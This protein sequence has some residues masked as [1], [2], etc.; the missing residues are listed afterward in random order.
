[1]T[2]GGEVVAIWWTIALHTV[3]MRQFAFSGVLAHCLLCA[4]N[5]FSFAFVAA[6]LPF[7]QFLPLQW[8]A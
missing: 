3:Q 1:M 5:L 2:P 6:Q 8:I 7:L 4:L